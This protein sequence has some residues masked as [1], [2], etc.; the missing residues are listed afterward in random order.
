MAVMPDGLPPSFFVLQ[1]LFVRRHEPLALCLLPRQLARAPDR[2]RLFP[3]FAFRRLFIRT[4]TLHLTK[5]AFALHFLFQNTESLIDI[6]VADKN[7]QSMFLRVQRA[8][9]GAM[10]EP[11]TTASAIWSP[12]RDRTPRKGSYTGPILRHRIRN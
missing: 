4:P 1:P 3:G 9:V 8:C 6:V 5:Y 2:L 10:R 11:A 7:L 12:N